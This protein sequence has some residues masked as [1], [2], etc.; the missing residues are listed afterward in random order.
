VPVYCATKAAFHSFT[1]SLRHQLAKTPIEVVEIAP[2]AVNTDLGG[3][4]LHT[5]GVPLDEFVD[6]V[7][8][9]LQQGSTDVSYGFSEQTSHASRAE[10]EQIFARMNQ[11]P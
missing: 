5:H 9:Q 7:V 3:P 10:R 2:P 6:A 4:G 11:A 8:S 1:L